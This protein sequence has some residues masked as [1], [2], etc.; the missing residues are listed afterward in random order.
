MD[1]GINKYFG[2]VVMNSPII[3]HHLP[4]AHLFGDET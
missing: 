1:I 3:R 2:Y 4:L